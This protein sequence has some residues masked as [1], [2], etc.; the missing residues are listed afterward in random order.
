MTEATGTVH[1]GDPVDLS[2]LRRVHLIG[3]GGAGMSGIARLLLARGIEVTG[4][5]LKASR[6]LAGLR[7]AGATVFVGHRAEQ[8]GEPDAVV[9]SAAI[10]AGNI[11]LREAKRRDVPV[12]SRAQALAALMEGKRSVAVAGTHG[13]T[14]TTS[15][16]TVMLAR[17]GL[18]PS[19]VIGGDLNEIGSGAGHGEGA[20]FVAEADESDG[21]FLRYHPEVAVI[22]S[23]DEDHLD[24]YAGRADIEA[25]FRA[26][27]G[28]AGSIVAC[29]DDPGVRRAVAEVSPPVLRYGL[30]EGAELTVADE[31]LRGE[32][33]SATVRM[34]GTSSPLRLDIPGRHNLSNALAALGVAVVVGLPLEEAA[35]ALASFTG[36]RRRFED[37]GE[38]AGVAF[39]DDYAHNPAKVVAALQAARLRNPARLIAV[40]QPHRYTRTQAL[41]RP[42]GESLLGAD[43]VVVTDVYG[44]GESPI[45]GVTGKLLVDAVAEAAPGRRVVYVPRRTDVAPFLAGEVRP[46][47]LVLTLGAGDITIAGDAALERLRGSA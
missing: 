45:P 32:G 19:F 46:G 26:F 31:I 36:V 39:V 23:I 13:K 24:F 21:S 3:I 5:D 12:M 15:M 30:H 18:D 41:W 28:Q 6:S 29:W 27:A 8:L 38:A 7:E 37:R 35:A 20:F 1:S 10:P 34:N 22:T 47:D 2:A 40:F 43:L 17:L 9:V 16:I 25:A 4:S 42:L 11:E 33:T 14:T 44:A